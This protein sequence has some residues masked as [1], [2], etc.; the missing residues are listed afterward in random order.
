MN[1]AVELLRES[2]VFYLATNDGDQP[3][4]RPF[5]AVA[6]IDEKLYI[7]TSNDKECFR[8]MLANPKVEIAGMLDDERWIRVCGTV[9]VDSRVEAKEK[10]LKQHPLDMYKA[11]D[12]IFEI[13]YFTSGNVKIYSFSGEPESF[14]L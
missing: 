3:K 12:G 8:Q 10:F 13:L 2:G 4:V 5:G 11:D 1:R 9:K 7:C 6:D 14:E